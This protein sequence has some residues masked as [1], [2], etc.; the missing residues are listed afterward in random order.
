MNEKVLSLS[1]DWGRGCL[2][3]YENENKGEELGGAWKWIGVE[4]VR[5]CM[6]KGWARRRRNVIPLTGTNFPLA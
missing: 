6:N 1:L 3:E 2:R 5:L 4:R